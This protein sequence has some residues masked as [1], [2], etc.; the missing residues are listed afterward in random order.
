MSNQIA[1]L[2]VRLIAQVDAVFAPWR[3]REPRHVG[4]S[5]HKLQTTYPD[6]GLPWR[7]QTKDPAEQK[8]I[9]RSLGELAA[10]GL[11][12]IFRGG[13]G[14]A[15]GFRLTDA[16][17]WRGRHVARMPNRANVISFLAHLAAL[18]KSPDV[19]VDGSIHEH[20]AA[21]GK[22][23]SPEEPVELDKLTAFVA[24]ARLFGWLTLGI[25]V[26]GRCRYWLTDAGRQAIADDTGGPGEAYD[27]PERGS[28]VYWQEYDDYRDRLRALGELDPQ[29]ITPLSLAP[30]MTKRQRAARQRRQRRQAERAATATRAAKP[31]SE[32]AATVNAS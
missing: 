24:P 32:P 2:L 9:E 16:G 10:D 22:P 5:I 25:E 19:C 23:G 7:S 12:D 27:A 17:Y 20:L 11:A 29:E 15:T 30:V 8:R 3:L 13:M 31:A 18:G 1:E 14:R 4:P 6:R 26:G 21:G 28:E